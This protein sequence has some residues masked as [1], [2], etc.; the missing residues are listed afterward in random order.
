MTTIELKAPN[1][2]NRSN[3]KKQLYI[4]RLARKAGALCNF[5]IEPSW[6]FLYVPQY[7]LIRHKTKEG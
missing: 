4:N 1:N 6:L 5:N 2:K 7:Q 3:N